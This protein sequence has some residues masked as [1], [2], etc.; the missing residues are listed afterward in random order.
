M[1]DPSRVAMILEETVEILAVVLYTR[2][3]VPV[4]SGTPRV[5]YIRAG[6]CSILELDGAKFR[7]CPHGEIFFRLVYA[8]KQKTT[9]AFGQEQKKK[10]SH[11]RRTTS[12]HF[13]LAIF[14]LTAILNDQENEQRIPQQKLCRRIYR[15]GYLYF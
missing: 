8:K 6:F 1:C 2:A 11:V 5:L 3:G 15:S 14:S 10:S 13:T 7:W 4:E 9:F 12:P